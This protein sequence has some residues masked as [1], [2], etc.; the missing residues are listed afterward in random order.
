MKSFFDPVLDDI[1][2]QVRKTVGDTD[3][4]DNPRRLKVRLMFPPYLRRF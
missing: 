4:L 1:I 2:A 3:N